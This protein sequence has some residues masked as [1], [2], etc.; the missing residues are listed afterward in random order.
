MSAPTDK[1]IL[2]GR[3]EAGR[4]LPGVMPA[5]V[6]D[7]FGFSPVATD[8]DASSSSI[9][10]A[11]PPPML[12]RRGGRLAPNPCYRL[13][14]RPRPMLARRSDLQPSPSPS[15][16]SDDD[17]VLSASPPQQQ[18]QSQSSDHSGE[19]QQQPKLDAAASQRLRLRMWSAITER[20]LGIRTPQKR[21]LDDAAVDAVGKCSSTATDASRNNGISARQPAAAF[22]ITYPHGRC[23]GRGCLGVCGGRCR[24]EPSVLCHCPASGEAPFPQLCV[25]CQQDDAIRDRAAQR[26]ERLQQHRHD[27]AIA[28]E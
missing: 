21:C 5:A 26:L 18:P 7:R 20:P 22:R 19:Q 16:S 9:I 25:H 17:P 12:V 3:D 8:V 4:L 10:N 23:Q 11:R 6:A 28:A 15:P 1:R 2:L 13:P 27:Q 24:P 14:P